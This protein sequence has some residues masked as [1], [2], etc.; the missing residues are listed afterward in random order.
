MHFNH[1]IRLLIQN[2]PYFLLTALILTIFLYI[3]MRIVFHK[4][5]SLVQYLWF[6]CFLF[7]L[8]VL[9]LTTLDHGSATQ[10]T[11]L[12]PNF[13]PFIEIF[14][15]YNMGFRKM[16]VQIFINLLLLAPL[17][18]LLPVQFRKFQSFPRTALTVLVVSLLIE[19]GQYFIGR[20]A[21]VDDVIINAV[22]GMFGY[23][24]FMLYAK[25]I[26]W[27]HSLR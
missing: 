17:G 18:F 9:Y 7:Y 23:L 12:K 1:Y 26:K 8:Q 14:Q 2:I 24:C 13:I 11:R 16:M 4:K 6:F 10:V 21:D 27:F 19:T 3:L 5:K 15:V 22:G 25:I 20:S